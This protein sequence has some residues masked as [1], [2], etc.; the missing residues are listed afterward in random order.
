MYEKK[1]VIFRLCAIISKERC[2]RYSSA[3]ESGGEVNICIMNM[4]V[5]EIAEKDDLKS[6]RGRRERKQRIEIQ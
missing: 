3:V 5:P 6:D 4:F 1:G 2:R